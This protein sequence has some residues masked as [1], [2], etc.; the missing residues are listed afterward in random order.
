MATQSKIQQYNATTLFVTRILSPEF[1]ALLNKLWQIQ[2]LAEQF[3]N[4]LHTPK[5]LPQRTR[6]KRPLLPPA[7]PASV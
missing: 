4:F 1:F 3:L 2:I 6:I 5:I 7:F